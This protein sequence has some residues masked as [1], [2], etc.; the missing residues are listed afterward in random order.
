MTMFELTP[1][2]EDSVTSSVDTTHFVDNSKHEEQ[3]RRRSEVTLMEDY[4]ND[5]VSM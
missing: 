2:D 5:L 3:E 1:S 4:Q